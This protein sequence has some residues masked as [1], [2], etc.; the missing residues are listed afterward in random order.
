VVLHDIPHDALGAKRE[1]VLQALVVSKV[2]QE[3]DELV[4]FVEEAVFAINV[5]ILI[6][7]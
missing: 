5:R 3:A 1:R 4:L 2:I 7:L 6:A